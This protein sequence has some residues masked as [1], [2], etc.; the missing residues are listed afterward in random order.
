MGS[1]VSG[2]ALSRGGRNAAPKMP[3]TMN[4]QIVRKA[5]SQLGTSVDSAR[6]P[7]MIA[8]HSATTPTGQEDKGRVLPARQ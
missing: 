4:A 5:R 3:A 2:K 8:S 1:L 6:K 7:Q